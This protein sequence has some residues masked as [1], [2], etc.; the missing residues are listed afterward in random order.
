MLM[1]TLMHGVT[2]A[3]MLQDCIEIFQDWRCMDGRV[4]LWLAV[5]QGSTL[6]EGK[7]GNKQCLKGYDMSND[8]MASSAD[9]IM[10]MLLTTQARFILLSSPS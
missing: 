10:P 1:I 4:R 6:P 2:P 5:A 3:P 9:F 8:R 7:G